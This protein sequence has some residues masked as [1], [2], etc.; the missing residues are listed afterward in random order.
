MRL[1]QMVELQT[2]KEWIDFM[3]ADEL[4]TAVILYDDIDEDQLKLTNTRAEKILSTLGIVHCAKIDALK[5]ANILSGV[6][7]SFTSPAVL[8]LVGGRDWNKIHFF[9]GVSLVGDKFFELLKVTIAAIERKK[10]AFESHRRLKD[11]GSAFKI[12][13][14]LS[15]IFKDVYFCGDDEA[16][17][18]LKGTRVVVVNWF[19]EI[20]LSFLGPFWM[21]MKGSA[22]TGWTYLI[23]SVL[24]VLVFFPLALLI[25][26]FF[27]IFG[28]VII[29]YN[30]Y[31]KGFVRIDR[32]YFQELKMSAQSDATIFIG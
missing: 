2:S 6:G 20:A 16:F 3:A 28:R 1:E 21:M 7:R 18:K 30:L 13:D 29:I 11:K 23:F 9:E 31:K 24:A 12:Y 27:I 19:T 4:L 26:I 8:I 14:A 32:Q 15:F 25:H 22:S 17:G 5:N 10:K